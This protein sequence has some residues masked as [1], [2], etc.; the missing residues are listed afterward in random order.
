MAKQKSNLPENLYVII[1]EGS[2]KS[3]KSF[4]YKHDHQAKKEVLQYLFE[5]PKKTADEV[6]LLQKIAV[7]EPQNTT[8]KSLEEPVTIYRSNHHSKRFG[9][10]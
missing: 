3:I 6:I 8:I 2:K 5:T 1:R 10:G 9:N 7:Y 4:M